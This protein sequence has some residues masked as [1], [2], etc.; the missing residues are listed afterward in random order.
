MSYKGPLE[1]NG[2]FSVPKDED[3]Q[4]LILD[5]QRGN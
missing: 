5:A 2:L 4:R 3:N 1:I